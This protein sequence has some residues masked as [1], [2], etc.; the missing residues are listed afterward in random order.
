MRPRYCFPQFL[1][2]AAAIALLATIGSPAH[3]LTVKRMKLSNG[4]ILLVSPEHRLPMV[5]MAMAFIGAGSRSDPQDE[6]GLAS[7]TAQCLTEGTKTLSADE[8]NRKIDFMGSSIGIGVQHDYAV[9]NL[10]SLKRYWPQTLELLAQVLTEPA[11]KTADI[12]RKRSE[13]LAVLKAAEQDP[14]YTAE[15]AFVKALFGD[16]PYG[17]LAQGTIKSVEKLTPE[18][19]RNFYH[20]HYRP[21]GSV[22]A[23]VGDVNPQRVEATL[24]KELAALKGASPA[25]SAAPAPEVKK[26]IR[27]HVIDRNVAQANLVV[28]SAGVARSNPDFYRIRVMNYILGGGGFASRLV[29][30]VRTRAGLAYSV[31]SFYVSG[32]Y[33]GSFQIVLQT[34]NKSANEA[35]R[36]VMTQMREMQKAP[37]SAAELAGAKKFL[38]GSFPLELDTQSSIA[39]FLLQVEIYHLGLDYAQRYPKLIDAVTAQDVLAAARKYLHPDHLIVV[40]VANQQVAAVNVADLKPPTTPGS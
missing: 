32:I 21:E 6:A 22:I 35:L 29:K 37:V 27:L 26:G 12:E 14:G 13:Q 39:N 9:A 25:P 34:K 1:S 23:V 20:A 8:F 7:L 19:V 18:D 16:T 3:A 31:A 28:G 11:L 2:I 40:A 10:T 33:P 15:A 4:A 38:V 17:H 24:N 30:R 36:L 5:T